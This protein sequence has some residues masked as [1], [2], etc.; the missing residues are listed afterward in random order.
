MHFEMLCIYFFPLFIFWIQDINHPL[1]NHDHI[2]SNAPYLLHERNDTTWKRVTFI[3]RSTWNVT[4][5]F[6]EHHDFITV[7]E[8]PLA[9]RS[10][11][12]SMT[13]KRVDAESPLI[14]LF[15]T[16]VPMKMLG[17]NS[18]PATPLVSFLDTNLPGAILSGKIVGMD[19]VTVQEEG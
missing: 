3:P 4:T 6:S 15:G 13:I 18:E 11:E 5:G 8:N 14:R 7:D 1:L 16:A 19:H 10:L 9:N 17:F 2:D 12:P